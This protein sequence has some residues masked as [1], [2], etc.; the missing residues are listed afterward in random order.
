M[1]YA[2]PAP[3]KKAKTSVPSQEHGEETYMVRVGKIP[4][5]TTA[6]EV[7][8]VFSTYGS[9]NVLLG[10]RNT[11]WLTFNNET[12]ALRA[13][14]YLKKYRFPHN[15]T[16]T[17]TVCY[18]EPTASPDKETT[19][20]HSPILSTDVESTPSA[21]DPFSRMLLSKQKKMNKVIFQKKNKP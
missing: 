10:P 13:V 2:K 6:D 12:A 11:A 9:V 16:E 1:E 21:Q 19:V 14:H 4:M 7:K 8:S 18:V 17:I 15:N 3:K 5:N 20:Q